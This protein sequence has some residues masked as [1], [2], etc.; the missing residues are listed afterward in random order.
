MIQPSQALTTRQRYQTFLHLFK[1][2][3]IIQTITVLQNII[4]RLSP[5]IEPYPPLPF[6]SFS[7]LHDHL[8]RY[9]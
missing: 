8:W 5:F 9:I 7:I 1:D 6:H 3:T 4:A 2:K